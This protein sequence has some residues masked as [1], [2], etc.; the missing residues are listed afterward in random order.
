MPNILDQLA[1]SVGPAQSPMLRPD[2]C[3]NGRV[4]LGPVSLSILSIARKTE[5]PYYPPNY[6]RHKIHVV[7]PPNHLEYSSR[8]PFTPTRDAEIKEDVTKFEIDL[9]ITFDIFFKNDVQLPLWQPQSGPHAGHIAGLKI[10]L[11]SPVSQSPSL[12]LHNLGQPS[13]D[14]QLSDRVDKLFR[15]G[16]Q[17]R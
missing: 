4:I 11:V 10:P 5:Q 6:N 1:S 12:L 15:Q 14:P 13:H 7:T 16:E 3:K 17:Q 8:I 2:P 9:R